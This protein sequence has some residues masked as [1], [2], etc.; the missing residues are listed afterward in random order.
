[1]NVNMKVNDELNLELLFVDYACDAFDVQLHIPQQ[2]PR[3]PNVC[4]ASCLLWLEP[5]VQREQYTSDDCIDHNCHHN[6][7]NIVGDV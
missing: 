5:P 6:R 2:T 7:A 1:M 3:I 4:G